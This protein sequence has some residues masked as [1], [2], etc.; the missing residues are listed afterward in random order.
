MA[1]RVNLKAIENALRSVRVG[2]EENARIIPWRAPV[3]HLSW[4]LLLSFIAFALLSVVGVRVENGWLGWPVLAA[5]MTLLGQFGHISE[6]TGARHRTSAAA[7][8]VAV[9]A[10]ALYGVTEWIGKPARAYSR[11]IEAVGAVLSSLVAVYAFAAINHLPSRRAAGASLDG[12]ES[13]DAPEAKQT[14]SSH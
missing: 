11:P 5:G 12:G 13:F 6:G 3:I 7:V 14:G 2:G 1:R 8:G 9:L 4:W 10:T